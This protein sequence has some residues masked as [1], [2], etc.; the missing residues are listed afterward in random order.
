MLPLLMLLL[1]HSLNSCTRLLLLL[2]LFLPQSFKDLGVDCS[3][4]TAPIYNDLMSQGDGTGEGLVRAYFSRVGW[5][6]F[7]PTK[8][9]DIF[10]KYMD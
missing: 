5:P 4:W 9:E 8:E 7:L 6:T 2:L 3:K 1:S 10:T